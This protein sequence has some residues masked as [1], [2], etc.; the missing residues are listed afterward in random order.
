[1]TIIVDDTDNANTED[2]THADT[3]DTPVAD[4]GSDTNSEGD[5]GVQPATAEPAKSE[6]EL[7]REA[8]DAFKAAAKDVKGDDGATPKETPQGDAAGKP[9]GD[10]KRPEPK[11]ADPTA[12]GDS[13]G[14]KKPVDAE[15]EKEVTALGL[16]GKS[17]ERFREMAGEIKTTRPMMEVL[18]RVN[19]KDA[20]Q[21]DA[22]LRDASVGLG[23]EK[24]I[25]D[26]KAQPEQLKGAMQIIGAMN[27][28]KPELQIQAAQAMLNEAKAVLERHGIE[29]AGVTADPL[30]KHPDL[31]QAFEAMDITREHALEMAKLR[32]G[33][34]NRAANDQ[35]AARANQERASAEAAESRV[36][37]D[38]DNLSAALQKNDPHFEYKFK[39]MQASGEFDRIKALPLNQR[40]QALVNAYNGVPNPVAAPAPA[41]A[42]VRP[43]NVTNRGNNVSGNGVART[44][45]KSDVEAFRAGVDAVRNGG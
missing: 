29:I 34:A 25:M 19:V 38:I 17:A 9:A 41:Q 45:F 26:A 23:Y 10:G 16:K 37:A 30:D 5:A 28:G 4:T 8:V 42:R 7:Q 33:N 14:D 1:M 15:L 12:T 11:K 35:A 20:Q 18:G 43:T 24:I 32:A 44:E 6:E 40:Y 22:L 31:K 27:T 21:L 39:A 36:R 2:L 13:K 3:A